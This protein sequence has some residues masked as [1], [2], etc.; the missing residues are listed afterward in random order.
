M[1]ITAAAFTVLLLL[2][3]CA[4]PSR[5]AAPTPPAIPSPGSGTV[6]SLVPAESVLTVYAYRAGAL[7]SFGHNHVLV[8]TGLTGELHVPSDAMQVSGDIHARVA[9]FR[10]DEPAARQAAG[11][12]FPGEI[13]AGDIAGT[14][15]N[16]LGPQLLDA[17][18][19]PELHA[20]I[21]R[22]QGGPSDYAV[23]VAV[24]VRGVGTQQDF[25]ARVTT[26]PGELAADGEISL[27]QRALGLAPFS[28]LMGALSVDDSVRVRY[29]IVARAAGS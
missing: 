27:S 26:S 20:S 8:L 29:H 4:R 28:I 25:P 5:P 18:H 13:A 23:S 14:R 6:Y 2:S 7:A 1:R 12:D 3:A 19:F 17:A 24:T 16:M 15:Q 22:A 9:D 10:V 11:A 21:L